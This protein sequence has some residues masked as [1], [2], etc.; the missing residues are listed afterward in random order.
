MHLDTPE[1][2]QKLVR[3]EASGITVPTRACNRSVP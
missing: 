1:F 3:K 2:V